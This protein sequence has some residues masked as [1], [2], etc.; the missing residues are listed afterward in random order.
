MANPYRNY[1]LHNPYTSL[2]LLLLAL[3][4]NTASIAEPEPTDVRQRAVDQLKRLKDLAD[5][6]ISIRRN[7]SKLEAEI[8]KAVLSNDLSYGQEKVVKSITNNQV[9]RYPDTN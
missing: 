8:K 2:P 9:D 4:Q 3:E 7:V 6:A 5:K 1:H